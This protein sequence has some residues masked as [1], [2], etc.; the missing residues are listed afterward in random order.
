MRIKDK[1]EKTFKKRVIELGGM[2]ER[3]K[4]F[5]K[6]GVFHLV[7]DSFDLNKRLLVSVK[8]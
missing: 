1:M 5:D 8:L 2:L 4:Q 3:L 7:Q 6:N